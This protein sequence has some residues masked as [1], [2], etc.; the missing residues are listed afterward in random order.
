MGIKDIWGGGGMWGGDFSNQITR[1]PKQS[2][3][4]FDHRDYALMKDIM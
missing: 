1:S 3:V 4:V 2:V